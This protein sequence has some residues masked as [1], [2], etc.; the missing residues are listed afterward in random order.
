MMDEGDKEK[1]DYA[2]PDAGLGLSDS[3]SYYHPHRIISGP[4]IWRILE[5]F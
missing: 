5:F 1:D 2:L 4:P 3:F